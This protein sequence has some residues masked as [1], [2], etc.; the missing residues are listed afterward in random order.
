[1]EASRGPVTAASN[2]DELRLIG[3][4]RAGAVSRRREAGRENGKG[5]QGR[6]A[7]CLDRP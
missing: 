6:E 2:A 5:A 1:M 3:A 4:A 7:F